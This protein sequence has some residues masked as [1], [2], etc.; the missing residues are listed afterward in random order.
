MSKNSMKSIYQ[1]E[2]PYVYVVV[3]HAT[4]K[5]DA[6]LHGVYT[7]KWIAEQKS[8][9]VRE[10]RLEK[11]QPLGYVAVLKKP[12]EGPGIMNYEQL[13]KKVFKGLKGVV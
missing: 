3:E 11:K 4:R 7:D 5:N 1:I 12:I 8:E 6:V 2:K 10:K 13:V 9:W